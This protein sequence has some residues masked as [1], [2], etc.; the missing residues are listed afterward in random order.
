MFFSFTFVFSSFIESFILSF[1]FHS[2]IKTKIY[3][4]V[5]AG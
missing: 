5:H 2:Q 4:N 1:S 3:P